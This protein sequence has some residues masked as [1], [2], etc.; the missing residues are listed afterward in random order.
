MRCILLLT[1]SRIHMAD[2]LTSCLSQLKASTDSDA[3]SDRLTVIPV[4]RPAVPL[5]R[6]VPNRLHPRGGVFPTTYD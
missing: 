5:R 2:V 4:P 6:R 3:G 1:H